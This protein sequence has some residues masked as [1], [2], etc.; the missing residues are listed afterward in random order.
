MLQDSA[1][2]SNTNLQNLL[3]ITAIKSDASR[4]ADYVHRLDKFEPRAVAQA[5]RCCYSP[6]HTHCQSLL[7]ALPHASSSVLLH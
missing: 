5:R 2:S 4:V 6:C 3:I 1:F 7:L